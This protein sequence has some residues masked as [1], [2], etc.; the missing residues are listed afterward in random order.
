MLDKVKFSSN[1][2]EYI[3]P[4]FTRKKK[5]CKNLK[6]KDC[7][8]DDFHSGDKHLQIILGRWAITSNC[9]TNCKNYFAM[10]MNKWSF[11]KNDAFIHHMLQNNFFYKKYN[12]LPLDPIF[13]IRIVLSND[14][15]IPPHRIKKVTNFIKE[16]GHDFFKGK[17]ISDRILK[18]VTDEYPELTKDIT[19][20]LPLSHVIS[21]ELCILNQENLYFYTVKHK[22]QKLYKPY[23][24][25][26]EKPLHEIKELYKDTDYIFEYL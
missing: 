21:R 6:I 13:P 7:Q 26:S 19:K 17:A 16:Y 25:L 24:L 8:L 3:R 12:Q 20:T 11:F 5:Y 9:F 1:T 2:G 22:E 14:F 4:R 15:L 23:V 10:A 18:I